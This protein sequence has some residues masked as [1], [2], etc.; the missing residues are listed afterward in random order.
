MEQDQEWRVRKNG[1]KGKW[2]S[3]PCAKFTWL[4]LLFT[5]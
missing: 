2:N 4:C 1:R 5:M 3:F